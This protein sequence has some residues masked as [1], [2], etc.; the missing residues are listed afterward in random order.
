MSRGI[1]LVALSLGGIIIREHW[2]RLT[3]SVMQFFGHGGQGR[4]NEQNS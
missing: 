3:C 1:G 4:S 2:E